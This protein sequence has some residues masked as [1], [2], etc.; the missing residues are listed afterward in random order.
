[1]I[2]R[3]RTNEVFG[4]PGIVV[5][6]R[7][8]VQTLP[9]KHVCGPSPKFAASWLHSASPDADKVEKMEEEEGKTRPNETQEDDDGK[10]DDKET[11]TRT[12]T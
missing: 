3:I 12:K 9:T 2:I 11:T 1:M 10:E 4:H 8:Q 6:D 7:P 5:R